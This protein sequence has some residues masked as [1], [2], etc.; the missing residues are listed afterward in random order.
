MAQSAHKLQCK[1]AER[2]PLVSISVAFRCPPLP[3]ARIRNT[4]RV[5]VWDKMLKPDIVAIGAWAGGVEA[6]KEIV[7]GLPADLNAARF[8]PPIRL[9]ANRF[10]KNRFTWPC[11]IIT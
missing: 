5:E 4:K 6:L 8:A 7:A 2:L 1:R 9:M 10:I 11:R 3:E